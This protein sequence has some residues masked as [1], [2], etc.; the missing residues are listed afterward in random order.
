VIAAPAIKRRIGIG[1]VAVCATLLTSACAAGQRAATA[2]VVAAIDATTGTVG[3]LQLR[4]V[5]IKPPPGGP[6]YAAG[7]AAELQLV[8]VNTGRTTDTL[9]SV[10]SPAAAGY[11]VFA[12]AAEASTAASPS[13]TPTPSESTSASGST[14]ASSSASGTPTDSASAS[15]SSSATPSPSVSLQIP[16]GQALT[17]S[18]TDTQPVL[19]IKLTKALFPGTTVQVTFTFADAGS[20]TLTVPIQ[21]TEGATAGLTVSPPSETGAA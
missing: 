11:Q 15:S 12:T 13:S 5:A 2:N 21:I 10:S 3:D 6:S 17:L 8:I 18:V 4:D 19:L 16:A 14:S 9:R 7:D 1:L 20:V